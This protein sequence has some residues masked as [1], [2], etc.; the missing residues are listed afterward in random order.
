MVDTFLPLTSRR[1]TRG[2][3]LAAWARLERRRIA[4]HVHKLRQK[5]GALT[6]DYLRERLDSLM[7]FRVLPMVRATMAREKPVD[8]I[9]S[10]K[11]LSE[12][13]LAASM[14]YEARPYSG[15]VLLC[16]AADRHEET[17]RDYVIGW[18]DVLIGDLDVLILTGDHMTMFDPENVQPLVEKL[19]GAL[20]ADEA[21]GQMA[22][23]AG[24]LIMSKRASS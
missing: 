16:T 23:R 2:G 21:G 5:E 13:L 7:R 11:D 1:V 24:A 18:K 6:T 17:V 3:Q 20:G 14:K 19:R 22:G 4:Y 10:S 9:R 12:L 15:R 8:E